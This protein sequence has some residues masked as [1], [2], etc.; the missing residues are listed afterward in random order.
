MFKYSLGVSLHTGKGQNNL[1][2]YSKI[3][4]IMDTASLIKQV[5]TQNT[6]LLILYEQV[7][8]V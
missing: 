4:Y 5:L 6:Y 8:G 1:R 3:P 2:D 7:G